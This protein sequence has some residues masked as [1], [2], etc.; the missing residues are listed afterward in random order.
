L[1][2]P[3]QAATDVMHCP[4]SMPFPPSIAPH[5]RSLSRVWRA[6]ASRCSRC[7]RVHQTPLFGVTNRLS[8]LTR[9]VLL[10]TPGV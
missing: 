7:F 5:A 1:P 3:I 9:C 4:A 2:Y 6:V 8:K 10:A